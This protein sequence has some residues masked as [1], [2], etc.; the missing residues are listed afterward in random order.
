MINK[1]L[2]VSSTKKIIEPAV[3]IADF[4]NRLITIDINTEKFYEF[5]VYPKDTITCVTYLDGVWYASGYNSSNSVLY[6]SVDALH[7]SKVTDKPKEQTYINIYPNIDT[8]D[9]SFPYL[10][11]SGNN[12]KLEKTSDVLVGKF[13]SDFITTETAALNFE[14]KSSIPVNHTVNTKTK[15]TLIGCKTYSTADSSYICQYLLNSGNNLDYNIESLN[16]KRVNSDYPNR[17]VY[18]LPEYISSEDHYYMYVWM[19]ESKSSNVETNG[20]SYS[21]TFVGDGT[22]WESVRTWKQDL[23]FF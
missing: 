23:K 19:M 8:T 5:F 1:K 10:F 14:E 9:T 22:G 16:L 15:Q 7:W 12:T 17:L 18:C 11:Y 4:N 21:C 2:L 20:S 6:K 13:G 3:V